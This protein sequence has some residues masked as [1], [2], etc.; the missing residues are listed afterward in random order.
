MSDVIAP[1]A[2]AETAQA[3]ETRMPRKLAWLLAFACAVSVANLYY[4]QPVLP[5]MGRT[6]SVTAGQIGFVATLTQFGYAAGLLFIIPLGDRYRRR[7]LI[8]LMLVLVALALVAVAISPSLLILSLAS[9]AVGATTIV[10]QLI[11]PMAAGMAHPQERGRVIGVV[12]T[13]LLI[14]ILLARTFSGFI[15]AQLGWRVVYWIAAA[16]M[17]LLAVA[18][19]F[20]L[21]EEYPQANMSYPQLLKSL[22]GLFRTEPVLR[23]ASCIGALVFGAFS[24]FWA[25]LSFFLETPPYHY[26][27]DVAGTFGLVGVVGALAASLVG[28]IA[29]RHNP[30]LTVGFALGIVLVSFVI[31][32]LTGQFLWGLIIGV[33]LL[34]LG[35]QANQVSNQ[36]RIYSLNPAA[37]NRLNTV[38][39]VFYF[40]GG[41]IG[42]ALGAFGWSFAKWNGVCLIAC[43]LLVLALL[44]YGVNSLRRK[45]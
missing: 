1:T 2:A 24:A 37:R 15:S 35:S 32:W 36:A 7:L 6:F 10:P 43:I 41:S 22:W 4:I 45:M 19:H 40:V 5:D 28:R 20:L 39:M 12:M 44:L 26:G 9:F 30:R 27:S 16:M 29:D 34:D 38:Y 18:L 13:G 14:G 33:I 8:C 11:I 42:S 3:K 21:P 23:E 17:I 25:T 31:F